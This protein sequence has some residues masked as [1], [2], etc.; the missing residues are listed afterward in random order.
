MRVRVLCAAVI[1]LLIAAPRAA[2]AWTLDYDVAGEC[3]DAEAFRARVETQRL[4]NGDVD[5]RVRVSVA[6]LADARWAARV[7]LGATGASAR[8]LAGASCAEVHDA[9]IL[10]V[11]QLLDGASRPIVVAAAT[12]RSISRVPG[13]D[14][15]VRPRPPDPPV[16]IRAGGG[17]GA[18]ARGLAAPSAGARLALDAG[19]QRAVLALGATR[20]LS[21]T[22]VDDEGQGLSMSAWQVHAAARFR[23]AQR[24]EVGAQFEIGELSARGRGVAVVLTDTGAWQAI[25]PVTRIGLWRWRRLEVTAD[26]ELLFPIGT[27]TFLVDGEP[28]YRTGTTFRGFVGAVWRVL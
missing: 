4:R 6:L 15:S 3:A 7:E 24:I 16:T 25:G 20:W 26:V 27:T 17:F 1:A 12:P 10:I 5:V 22:E 21:V 13:V 9:A 19:W 11:A 18:D 14:E 28:R 8:E 2:H 23:I